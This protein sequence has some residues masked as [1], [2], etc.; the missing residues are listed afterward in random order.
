MLMLAQT[1]N[2]RKHGLQSPDKLDYQKLTNYPKAQHPTRSECLHA[3][4]RSRPGRNNRD[5]NNADAENDGRR[6]REILE[7]KSKTQV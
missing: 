6:R 3:A 2:M 5:A 1:D 7:G 4:V